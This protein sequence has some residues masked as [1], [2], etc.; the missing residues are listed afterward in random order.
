ML[1]LLIIKLIEDSNNI[2]SINI[3][4]VITKAILLTNISFKEVEVNNKL[5]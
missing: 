5:I 3:A 2:I 4:L 1:N